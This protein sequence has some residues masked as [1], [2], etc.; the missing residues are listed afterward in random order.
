MKISI[1]PIQQKQDDELMGVSSVP[2][3]PEAV[4]LEVSG[5]ADSANSVLQKARKLI[6]E[7]GSGAMVECFDWAVRNNAFSSK[8]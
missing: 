2:A 3:R 1:I 6:E 4:M 7:N 8:G 5:S